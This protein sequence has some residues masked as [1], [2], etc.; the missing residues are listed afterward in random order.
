MNARPAGAAIHVDI[1]L[2][3]AV[4][5]GGAAG[6]VARHWLALEL[7]VGDGTSWP[8]ATFTANLAGTAVLGILLAAAAHLPARA[9]LLRPLVGAGFCGALTTFS[10]LQLELIE[11]G[12]AGHAWLAAG[13]L[14][15][16]LG[17]G[18]V[19]AALG[20]QALRG[21]RGRAWVARPAAEGPVATE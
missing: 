2:V 11:L 18:L 21:P 14:A 13:Y 19:L 1:R 3:V 10:T 4:A 6:A 12:R 16:S 5:L 9:A 15:A 17:G 8:W 7:P 20:W